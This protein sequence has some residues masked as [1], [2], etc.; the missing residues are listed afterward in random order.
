VQLP[1]VAA[2]AAP[3]FAVVPSLS[4]RIGK[5]RADPTL[6]ATGGFF[7]EIALALTHVALQQDGS[8][9]SAEI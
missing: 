7:I 3:S 1:S 8:V 4:S 2:A 6:E 9:L 5:H